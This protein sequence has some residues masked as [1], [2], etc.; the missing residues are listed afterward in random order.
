MNIRKIA[1]IYKITL[2]LFSFIAI[3]TIICRVIIYFEDNKLINRTLYYYAKDIK[4]DYETME[5]IVKKPMGCIKNNY[6]IQDFSSVSSDLLYG[7]SPAKGEIVVSKKYCEKKIF[8]KGGKLIKIIDDCQ[9][10]DLG[11]IIKI[12]E[13]NYRISGILSDR[14]VVP[15][16][17]AN[18]KGNGTL[19]KYDT[20]LV[21]D[22]ELSSI[23]ETDDYYY[24]IIFKSNQ[25]L[26]NFNDNG[27]PTF[28]E[29]D[30]YIRDYMFYLYL[31]T[32]ILLITNIILY[33]IRRKY[34]IKK[35]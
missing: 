30:I 19:E 23:C 25:Y 7:S 28:Y 33:F 1:K 3:I 32:I 27:N 6:I 21:S 4:Y 13:N 10:N 35:C 22:E 24:K 2:I 18:L 8:E 29:T 16:I 12:G 14:Y 15:N 34:G 31:L 11:K 17:Y 9:K 20:L 5:E 26:L